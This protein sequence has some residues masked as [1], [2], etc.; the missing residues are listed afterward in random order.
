MSN[1]MNPLMGL[2]IVAVYCGL[3]AAIS[4]CIFNK[5]SHIVEYTLNKKFGDYTNLQQTLDGKVIVSSGTREYTIQN[6]VLAVLVGLNISKGIQ[7][8]ALAGCPSVVTVPLLVGSVVAPI[9]FGLINI[10]I[11]HLGGHRG[12]WV[13][14]SDREVARRGINKNFIPKIDW[15]TPIYCGFGSAPKYFP[16]QYTDDSSHW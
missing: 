8:L 15:R 13:E 14:I 16:G 10:A 2:P 6:V 4:G 3:G 12:R 1:T 5:L 9:L 11:H 7:I